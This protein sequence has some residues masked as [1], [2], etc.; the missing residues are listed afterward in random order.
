LGAT[1]LGFAKR[2]PIATG[3]IQKQT[4]QDCRE[5]WPG[6]QRSEVAAHPTEEPEG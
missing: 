6:E 5:P 4:Q 2:V 3:I 1:E